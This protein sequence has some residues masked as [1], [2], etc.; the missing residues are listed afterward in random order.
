MKFR[1]PSL[2]RGGAPTLREGRIYT[3][4]FVFVV[5]HVEASSWQ[6]AKVWLLTRLGLFRPR[7]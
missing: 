4:D 3:E 7:S 6:R 5:V 1:R 2:L